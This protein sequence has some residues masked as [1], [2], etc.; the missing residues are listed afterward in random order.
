MD[1]G[2]EHIDFDLLTKHLAGEASTAEKAEVEAW[3]AASTDNQ[4][5]LDE[6]QQVFDLTDPVNVEAE[7]DTEAAWAKVKQQIHTETKEAKVVSMRPERSF[8]YWRVAAVALVLLGVVFIGNNVWKDI[9][10]G[11]R[12]LALVETTDDIAKDTLSDGTVIDLN[13]HSKLSYPVAFANDERRVKLKGE[14]FF[15]VTPNAEKPFII[16]AGAAEVKVL[17]TSFTVKTDDADELVTVVVETG[18]VQLS[19]KGEKVILLPGDKGTFN[20]QTGLVTKGKNDLVDYQFWRNHK[21]VFSNTSLLEVVDI[22]NQRYDAGLSIESPEAGACRFTA[23]F[24]DEELKTILT[25]LTTTFNMQLEEG[26]SG[27]VL[28]GSACNAADL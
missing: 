11:A 1:N 4:K 23:T 15:D 6:L 5:V 27:K 12:E 8:N 16:E 2:A 19:G 18:K 28:K 20:K 25:V 9:R 7:V 14:A 10:N 24:E 21:L 26:D 22:L 13:Q 17:G 3:L